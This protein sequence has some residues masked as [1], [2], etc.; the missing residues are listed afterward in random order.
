VFILS[1][2]SYIG[3]CKDIAVLPRFKQ[4]HDYKPGKPDLTDLPCSKGIWS[5][6]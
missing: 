5:G 6:E 2:F 4:I 3:G 1:S